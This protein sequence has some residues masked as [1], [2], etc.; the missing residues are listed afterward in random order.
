MGLSHYPRFINQTL[1]LHV[2]SVLVLYTEN[3][4]HKI[5]IAEANKDHTSETEFKILRHQCGATEKS[6]PTLDC[7]KYGQSSTIARSHA[8]AWTQSMIVY[9]QDNLETRM[10][11]MR[12]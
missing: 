8:V 10:A 3:P 9:C 5:P 12:S 6:A 2:V 4:T 7:K 1:F 11:C